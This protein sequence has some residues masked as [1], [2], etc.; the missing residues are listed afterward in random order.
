MTQSPT[1]LL[2]STSPYRAAL[3]ARLMI[4]FAREDPGINEEELKT[5]GRAPLEIARELALQK[6]RA[7]AARNTDVA[8]PPI[9]I[10]GDQLAVLDGEILGKPGGREQTIR[11]LQA[12]AGSTH[13]L[14]T[15]VAV[16]HGEIERTFVDRTLLTMRPLSREQIERYVDRDEPFDCAGGYKFEAHGITLFERVRC[17][18]VSAIT[19]LPLLELRRI[20]TEL[21]VPSP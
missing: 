6:A 4:E 11:Q 12:L 14:I 2:A 20:L 19:G 8:P 10:G 3:L 17:D 16:V 15:A 7:V 13:K 1:I 9:V 21:G 5:S 18:D